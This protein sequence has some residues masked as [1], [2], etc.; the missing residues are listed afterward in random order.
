MQN[1]PSLNSSTA[2][3]SEV[4]EKRQRI[5]RFIQ[6]QGLDGVLLNTHSFF[7]W[8]TAG[9]TNW[10]AMNND[11]GIASLLH[12]ANGE[13]Y[14]LTNNIEVPRMEQEELLTQLGYQII[15]H[16]WWQNRNDFLDEK[17]VWDLVG[18]KHKKL[19]ADF[20]LEG[21]QNVSQLLELERY[22]LTPEEAV[23]YRQVG[24]KA[25]EAIESVC[26]ALEPNMTEWEIAGR[27]AE[28]SLAHEISPFLTLVASD[29][30]IFKF[31]HPIPT[32]KKVEKYVMVV[33]C[34]KQGGL[35]ANCTRLVHFG[36]LT[37]ELKQKQA[38]LLQ[39]D[40]SF[41]LH[42]KAGA[43]VAEIFAK[44]Q[45]AYAETG[46]AQEWQLHHQGGAT[47][48]MGRDYFGTPTSSQIVQA[49]QAFAWNPS[50]TGIK[51][52]DTVL[53]SPEQGLEVL[54]K[55]ASSKWPTTQ[56]EISGLGA[57]ERPLILEK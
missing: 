48:Y 57:I 28:A 41:N 25:G 22:E 53:V 23:R 49:R 44:G 52:E 50:I 39:I 33:L 16:N 24:A 54:T 6:A 26:A 11:H 56:I 51:S 10:V 37:E 15:R 9:G 20:A 46:F 7:A 18:G 2:R 21:A 30:R 34:A 47:G 5:H 55:A 4:A 38:A 31:R 43:S 35:I 27:V 19:G 29:E 36:P 12:L 42:T 1:T 32:D 8:A 17:G 45:A 14:A 3:Q 13:Q 40:A